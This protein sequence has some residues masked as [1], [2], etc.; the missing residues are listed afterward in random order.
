M[1]FKQF[2]A[3]NKNK[4]EDL[5]NEDIIY[6]L[7]A[8]PLEDYIIAAFKTLESKHLKIT[9]YELITNENE[10]D[11]DTINIKHIKNKKNKKFT[12]RMGMKKSRYNL[13][14]IKF[15]LIAK[16][17][18]CDKEVNLLIFKRYNKYYYIIDGNRVYPIYQ[19]V[20]ASTYNTKN[21]LTLFSMLLPITMKKDEETIESV[22]F[23]KRD[24]NEIVSIEGKKYYVPAFT[25]C[26]FKKKIN[27]LLF[28]LALMGFENTLIYMNMD[29]IL[30]VENFK[31]YDCENEYCFEASNGMF[32]KIIK[33]FFDNDLFIRG[34][35]YLLLSLIGLCN[36]VNE[37]H[38]NKFWVC[39]LGQIMMTD[40]KDEIKMYIK[41]KNVL[42]SFYRL[43][44]TLT[45]KSLRLD[46]HNK[47]N[48]FA[49]IRWMMRNYNALKAKDNMDL[50]NKRLRMN[51]YIASYL[52]KRLSKRM[53]K[54]ISNNDVKLE[55][56]EL[57]I[58]M[59]QDY[60][61]KTVISSKKPLL[62]KLYHCGV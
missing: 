36:N 52:I 45:K 42:F 55:D 8:E 49:I 32:V 51:E 9:G 29:G 37:L 10:I 7:R 50:K 16:D 4:D 39:R 53:N 40:P 58:N 6:K 11:L 2:L 26:I 62:R 48:I 47:A 31:K 60:L 43:L 19:L 1:K 24:N 17:G 34:Q 25:L 15:H 3:Q 12:K 20:D 23:M 18:E 54:F 46:Y 21:C 61:L 28:Y 56:V 41:G 14:K 33:Y 13:L 35:V 30:R 59:E 5:I 27:P 38:D 44:D 22:N 57:L